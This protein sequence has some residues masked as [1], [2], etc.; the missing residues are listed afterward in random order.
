MENPKAR[1]PTQAMLSTSEAWP[2]R[3]APD[4]FLHVMWLE[5]AC[6]TNQHPES[7]IKK[8]AHKHCQKFSLHQNSKFAFLSKC[9]SD[10]QSEPKLLSFLY[11]TNVLLVSVAYCLITFS[12]SSAVSASF[13]WNSA[14][15][16][17]AAFWRHLN[18]IM[19]AKLLKL[20]KTF[21]R[22]CRMV[23]GRTYENSIFNLVPVFTR[24]PDFGV[25]SLVT[26]LVEFLQKCVR[27][28]W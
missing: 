17:P 11:T 21:L 22:H 8:K 5:F 7:T 14:E 1:H 24:K 27:H 9:K 23:L 10:S 25:S 28:V 2:Q 18:N 15:L 6:P 16:A 4:P 26:T 12:T 19:R 13:I 3:L 20:C